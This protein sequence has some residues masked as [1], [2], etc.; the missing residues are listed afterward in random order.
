MVNVPE[1]STLSADPCSSASPAIHWTASTGFNVAGLAGIVCI[2]GHIAVS[3][4]L[5]VLRQDV[6]R[7]S[8]PA[9]CKLGMIAGWLWDP[10]QHKRHSVSMAL[11]ED[12]VS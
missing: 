12:A 11:D 4:R 5:L 6:V 9:V 10:T 7:F 8:S 2:K 3:A 1:A